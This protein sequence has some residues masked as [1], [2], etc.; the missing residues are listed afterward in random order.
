MNQTLQIGLSTQVG[1]TRELQHFFRL[2]QMSTLELHEELQ[3]AVADNPLLECDD[4]EPEPAA[5]PVRI[6]DAEHEEFVAPTCEAPA[7]DSPAE[8]SAEI[9]CIDVSFS[10]PRHDDGE[11]SEFPQQAALTPS[12]RE[13]LMSQ[14]GTTRLSARDK[15]VVATL[16]AALHESGYLSESLED[17]ADLLPPE[18]RIERHELEIALE[19]LQNFDPIGVGAR[20]PA[21]C[22]ELQL[23]AL[24]PDTPARGLANEIVRNHLREL[25]AHDFAGLKRRLRCDD[26]SLSKAQQLIRILNPRPGAQY[27]S[28]ETRYIV[29][30]IIVK[31]VK[32]AWIARLNP[33]AMPKLRINGVYAALLRDKRQVVRSPMLNQLREARWLIK[34]V[35]SRFQTILRVAQA[36]VDQQCGFLERGDAGMRP[37]M[38]R[39]IADVIGVHRSTISRVTRQKFMATPRGIF[40]L[41]YF[42]GS[43]V[44]TE[45]GG[46]C[47]AIAIRALLKD[48]VVA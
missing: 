29:P 37:L 19:H 18:L 39:E 42:F 35:E 14:L 11:E 7:K 32:N 31:K 34:N 43:E 20:T 46:T 36:I 23:R 5:V 16:I 40:E 2:M 17:I 10:G 15:S 45:S 21:E 13:H 48:L 1:L 28:V 25:A 8:G 22:L 3:S 6:N 30:D 4:A 44:A 12:L 33:D 24:P 26:T 47:S 9:D 38:Q 27:E 41:N